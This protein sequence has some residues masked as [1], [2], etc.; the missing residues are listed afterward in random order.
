MG[1]KEAVDKGIN[2]LN[3]RF[4]GTDWL[5]DIDLDTFHVGSTRNCVLAQ[6]FGGFRLGYTALGF[7]SGHETVAYGFEVETT[8]GDNYE[9]LNDEWVSRLREMKSA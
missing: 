3:D 8:S 4:G 5:V 7:E 2:L 9:K 1:V 6:L